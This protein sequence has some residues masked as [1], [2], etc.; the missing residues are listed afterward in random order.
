MRGKW[1]IVLGACLL[2][3]G[4]P[5]QEVYRDNVVILLDASGSMGE[6]MRGTPVK[7]MASA[8]TAIKEVV[9][10]LP[11]ST[12]VGLL[13]FGSRINGWA[14]PLGM[15]DD[16]KLNKAIDSLHS[17]GGTPLGRYMKLAADRLLEE[18]KAQYGYGS[19]RLLI[20]TDGEAG[21]P[22][23][24]KR[25]TADIIS[26]GIV[27]DVIGVDMTGDHTLATKVHSYRRAND[28]ESLRKALQEVFAEVGKTGD[29]Q[30]G[31][32]AFEELD[33][34][35]DEMAMAMVKALISSGNHPIGNSPAVP[36][37]VVAPRTQSAPSPPEPVQP[38]PPQRTKS[39][40]WLVYVILGV[41][42]F[43]VIS[44]NRRR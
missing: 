30:S 22:D 4:S 8:K 39:R 6:A 13:V 28:P 14:Y 7:K 17:E 25:Y 12:Q 24:V 44:K 27:T 40:S 23:L 38:R 3:L 5:G 15:R 2:S 41:I 19:Y 26:R 29:D 11:Q 31:E 43:S 37:P 42:I 34:L 20:V 32:R 35:P 21:D 18:R 33:G 1:L 10:T 36:A 9:R 16:A